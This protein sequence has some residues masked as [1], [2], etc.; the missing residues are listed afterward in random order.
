MLVER[1]SYLSHEG[2]IAG[3]NMALEGIWLDWQQKI[4][5][6]PTK[7]PIGVSQAVATILRIV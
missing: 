1:G 4:L 2:D 6:K 5:P 7:D 3:I